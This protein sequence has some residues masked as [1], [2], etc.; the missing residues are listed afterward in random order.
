[1]TKENIIVNIP[2][3]IGLGLNAN[4]YMHLALLHQEV[5]NDLAPLTEND[6]NDLISR[7]YLEIL[8]GKEYLTSKGFELFETAEST[9]DTYFKELYE[10]FPRQVSDGKGSFRILRSKSLDSQDGET[11]KKKY[12]N[13]LKDD[14][15]LHKKIMKGLYTELHMRKNSMAYMQ[16]LQTWIN[17]KVWEKYWDLE[18][19]LGSTERVSSI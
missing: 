19:D 18:I 17:Q 1:M 9:I 16:N 14:K 12:S 3:L 5:K 11:C 15:D 2:T 13:V 7:E 10:A 6:L 4:Q 8:I